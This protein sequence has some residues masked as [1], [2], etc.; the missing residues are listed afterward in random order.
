MKDARPVSGPAMAF[1]NVAP[2]T[3][4]DPNA[5]GVAPMQEVKHDIAQP[6]WLH[7]LLSGLMDQ[8]D[9][10]RTRRAHAL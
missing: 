8:G 2:C 7:N 9:V 3:S 6:H 1:V 4:L 5:W 10:E